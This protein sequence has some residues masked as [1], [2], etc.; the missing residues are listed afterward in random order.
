M[1]KLLLNSL[2]AL[3]LIVIAIN[4]DSCKKSV[5]NPNTNN[6]KGS[7]SLTYAG[8]TIT[9]DSSFNSAPRYSSD[10]VRIVGKNK[11]AVL[12]SFG[13]NGTFC[14][15]DLDNLAIGTHSHGSY[16]QFDLGVTFAEDGIY[17]SDGISPY[18]YTITANSNNKI[19]GTFVFRLN[20][21]TLL[22]SVRGSFK[23]FVIP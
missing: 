14:Y 18:N 9:F 4:T 10:L 23:E 19:S 11:N 8:K 17:K 20:T 6:S 16:S 1:T 5:S 2:R 15:F 7:M 21:N 22:D 13:G 12:S 3:F